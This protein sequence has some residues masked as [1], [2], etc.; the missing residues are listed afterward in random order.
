MPYFGCWGCWRTQRSAYLTKVE[1]AER[2]AS[3]RPCLP[4]RKPALSRYILRKQPTAW[5][6]PGRGIL[7]AAGG[8]LIGPGAGVAGGFDQVVFQIPV[9]VVE[10]VALQVDDLHVGAHLHLLV[11]QRLVVAG[12]RLGVEAQ[13]PIRVPAAVADEAAEHPGEARDG[14]DGVAGRV[15][16]D[17]W[18][19]SLSS[20]VSRSSASSHSTHSDWTWDW[21]RRR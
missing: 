2:M 20:G 6:S 5:T 12:Q 9:G 10:E 11:Y 14:V 18:M 4:S 7:L 8:A 15:G 3:S 16:H 21:A 17:P 13:H 19:A 1:W